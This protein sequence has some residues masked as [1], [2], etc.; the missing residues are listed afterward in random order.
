MANL[1]TKDTGVETQWEL[2]EDELEHAKAC[3]SAL[4]AAGNRLLGARNQ[5][6]QLAAQLKEAQQALQA[7]DVAATVLW[8]G[9][10]R[11]RAKRRG[12]ALERVARSPLKRDG[13]VLTV[14]LLPEPPPAHPVPAPA[15][16]AA[17]PVPAQPAEVTA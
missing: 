1:V 10:M 6:L 5:V 12:V 8:R 14:I 17:E 11:L 7:E 2:D 4:Q 16:P 3:E 9:F 15:V 13:T